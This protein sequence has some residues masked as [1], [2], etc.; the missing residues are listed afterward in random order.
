MRPV[1]L[2]LLTLVLPVSAEAQRRQS[3]DPER[4]ETLRFD[5]TG[6]AHVRV[7]ID[8]P[9]RPAFDLFAAP[10][11]T[12]PVEIVLA[13]EG[14][15]AAK[16]QP[17]VLGPG[18]HDLDL[19]IE[20][21]GDGVTVEVQGRLR[22][23]PPFDAFEPNDGWETARDIDLPF[24]RLVR[25]SRGDAD[26]FRIDAPA[27][28]VI[29]IHLHHFGGN[30]QG[31]RIEVLDHRGERIYQTADNNFAWRSMRYVRAEGRPIHIGLSDTV[32]WA[33][34]RAEAFKALE[35]VHYRPDIDVTG[36]LV[37]LGLESEDP[38][39]FQLDL[40]GEALGRPVRSADEAESVAAE[41]GRAVEG[42]AGR[43]GVWLLAALGLAAV[44]AGGLYR[45]RR[46][47]PA[48]PEPGDEPG[49][50]DAG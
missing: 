33:E 1:L 29:G 27:G 20:A 2:L 10:P 46:R 28:G 7:D 22:F 14:E 17:R 37:T 21:P 41:L 9:G 3:L 5:E 30:Y 50:G 13:G 43:S 19:R 12:G 18:R 49:K 34:N 4:I 44:L 15:A 36:S 32:D 45:F 47:K 40:V 35:I 39:F 23:D 38:S 16:T 8:H 42:E 6:L 31:P 11:G 48:P 25:V 24:H 26:W